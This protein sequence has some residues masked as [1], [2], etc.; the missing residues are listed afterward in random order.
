MTR[1]GSYNGRITAH[2][3]NVKEGSGTSI[4]KAQ[5]PTQSTGK[6]SVKGLGA[7]PRTQA[8][9]DLKYYQIG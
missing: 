2:H 3:E 4:G 5:S 9:S 6:K 8:E 7:T 1:S